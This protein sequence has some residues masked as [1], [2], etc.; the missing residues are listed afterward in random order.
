MG[1]FALSARPKTSLKYAIFPFGQKRKAEGDTGLQEIKVR[2]SRE[3][4]IEIVFR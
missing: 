4:W 3:K 1:L 2:R